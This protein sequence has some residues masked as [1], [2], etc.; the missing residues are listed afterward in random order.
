MFA[1]GLAKQGPKKRVLA[2]ITQRYLPSVF[3]LL[4]GCNSGTNFAVVEKIRLKILKPGR[5][6]TGNSGV[7]TEPS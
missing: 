2:K 7:P 1:Y 6:I 5:R 4:S 3:L